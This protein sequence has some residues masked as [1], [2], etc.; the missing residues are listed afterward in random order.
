MS[1]RRSNVV[2]ARG[3]AVQ[4]CKV[5]STPTAHHLVK[6]PVTTKDFASQSGA[7][8]HYM[9]NVQQKHVRRLLR[10]VL[11]GRTGNTTRTYNKYTWSRQ[12]LLPL[13]I[14]RASDIAHRAPAG[15]LTGCALAQAARFPPA[16]PLKHKLHAAPIQRAARSGLGDSLSGV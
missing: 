7:S 14:V 1:T 13:N 9:H 10:I 5:S 8:R 4:T 12:P 3:R 6:M 2:V 16:G 15:S 11:S